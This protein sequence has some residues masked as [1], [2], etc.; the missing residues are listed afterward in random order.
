MIQRA[1][2]VS[3]VIALAVLGGCVRSDNHAVTISAP[4]VPPSTAAYLNDGMLVAKVRAQVVA[5]DLD[6]ATR[7]G[8]RVHNGDVVLTGVVRTAAE[9]RRI[10]QAVR[11]VHGVHD[12]HDDIRVDSRTPSFSGGDL[13]LA[14]HA[15]AALAAQ[16][17]V[18]A[19]GVRVSA[20]DGVVTLNGK[21]S[22]ESLKTTALDTVR[23]ISGVKRVVDKLHVGH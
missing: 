12:L 18:N 16:I 8:V 7:L 11:K 9:R 2:A 1:V 13:A 23:H 15:T 21:V 3:A 4:S 5:V 6:A 17:G 14:A 10:E 19:T 20:D 22:S